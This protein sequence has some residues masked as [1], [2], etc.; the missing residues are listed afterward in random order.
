MR[1]AIRLP[2]RF[3]W[4]RFSWGQWPWQ[5]QGSERDLALSSPT[6]SGVKGLRN[7]QKV[8]LCRTATRRETFE[9]E[10]ASAGVDNFVVNTKSGCQP[11]ENMP[12]TRALKKRRRT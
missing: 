3:L 10:G 7:A 5:F 6:Q 2:C 11:R 12:G 4:W 8:L 1:A 9:I